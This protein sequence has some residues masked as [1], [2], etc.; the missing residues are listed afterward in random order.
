MKTTLLLSLFL[1]S[2]ACQAQYL[3]GRSS[4]SF[5][6]WQARETTT[7]SG[8]S[9]ASATSI[10]LARFY[11]TVQADVLGSKFGFNINGQ[12]S[13]DFGDTKDDEL[14]I[15]QLT[16]KARR[17]ADVADISVGRQ[18]VL[19]G[20]G[21]GFLDGGVM[22]LSLIDGLVGAQAF[23]GYSLIDTR[24]FL[25]KDAS[26]DN[27]FYG[28]QI[29]ATPF[30]DVNVE[31]SYMKRSLKRDA[32]NLT[33]FD[34]LFNPT[35]VVM[36]YQPVEQEMAGF[37]LRYDITS[38]T[39]VY[40]RTDY[41]MNNERVHRVEASGR[42]GLSSSLAVTADYMYRMPLLQYNS[43]FSVFNY[44]ETQEA[45]GGLEYEFSPIARAYARYGYVKYSDDNSGRIRVGGTY[46]FISA[47]YSSN[48]GLAGDFSGISIQAAYPTADRKFVPALGFGYATYKISADAASNTVMNANL[49]LTYRPSAAVAADITAQW[50]Q[51]PVYNNDVRVF[52]RFSYLFS[53]KLSELL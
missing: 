40:M 43:I 52:L 46:D 7:P 28:G 47:S 37:D 13:R 29:S 19:S 39:N 50:I 8:S 48:T 12:Y 23:G 33:K 49:G 44:N 42:V 25:F 9:T 17:I 22:K 36:Y 2:M 24:T 20:V 6:T 27:G 38:G 30:T 53:K 1:I 41:D 15:S 3:S 11:E 14:R 16:F 5:Y 45:E 18:F 31:F 4:T 51:N 21:S 34:S 26:A 10:T 35:V 32:F